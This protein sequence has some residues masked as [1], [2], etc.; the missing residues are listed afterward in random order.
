MRVH[1]RVHRRPVSAAWQRHAGRR[2]DDAQ[3]NISTGTI[4]RGAV[5]VR[6]EHGTPS[7]SRHSRARIRDGRDRG[8]FHAPR[9]RIRG[10]DDAPRVEK[11]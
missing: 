8:A 11:G 3:R 6:H 10:G 7:P 2:A 5:S 4:V 1:R 9:G